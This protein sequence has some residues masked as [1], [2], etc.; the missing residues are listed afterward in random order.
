MEGSAL[1]AR[2]KGSDDDGLDLS[3]FKRERDYHSP[4]TDRSETGSQATRDDDMGSGSPSPRVSCRGV[5]DDEDHRVPPPPPGHDAAEDLSL[6]ASPSKPV[7]DKDMGIPSTNCCPVDN[8]ISSPGTGSN[9][10]NA[11]LPQPQLHVEG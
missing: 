7:D 4:P 6:S 5:S 3:R 11:F 1:A 2:L 10:S 9:P 8:N